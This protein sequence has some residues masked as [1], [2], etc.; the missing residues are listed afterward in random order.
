MSVP[1]GRRS[2]PALL[3]ILA[4]WLGPEATYAQTCFAPPPAPP[5]A[6]ASVSTAGSATRPATVTV[7]WV[8]VSTT[9]ANAVRSYII[10]VGNSPGVTNIA[11][12]DT[13]TTAV[14][15]EQ[16]AN[17]G[18]YY[19]RVR[20]VNACGV[21]APSP[22]PVVTVAGAI[23]ASEPGAGVVISSGR[24]GRDSFGDVYVVAEVRGAWGSR[25][26]PFVRVDAQFVGSVG[27]SVGSDF[28]YVNGRSRRLV[29]SR[30]VDDSTLAAGEN[31]CVYISTNIPY[32]RVSRVSVGTSWSS[33]S[34]LEGLRG[35]VSVQS[36]QQE[37]D[38]FGDLRVR[39]S[40]R[41]GG[42][43]LTYFNQVMIAARNSEDAVIDCDFTYVDGTSVR[44]PSGVTTTSGLLP[45]QTASFVNFGRPRFA[46]VR[47]VEAWMAWSEDD[48]GPTLPVSWRQLVGQ[49]LEFA[50]RKERT[51][52]RNSAIGT[53]RARDAALA[54]K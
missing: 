4:G 33:T 46:E 52:E 32:S 18:T 39:G 48:G 19:V 35:S 43:N 14:S 40:A 10:E 41:N 38:S 13:G 36:V 24:F 15:N 1:M 3:A 28:S 7:A 6:A 26:A 23:A 31:G 11:T 27:E 22:E 8:G 17:N 34:Q 5:N 51:K 2:L 30:I 53:L 44:L 49:G 50:S 54:E 29:A 45:G 20:S 47:R 16:K 9:G 42:T 21:S 25:A 12:L 37:S